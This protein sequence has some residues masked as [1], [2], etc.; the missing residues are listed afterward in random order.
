MWWR[1]PGLWSSPWGRL[2]EHGLRGGAGVSARQRYC[3][4][5]L[6]FV[7]GGFSLAGMTSSQGQC[8]HPVEADEGTDATCTE[9]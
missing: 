5:V 9:F 6:V 2:R 4:A 8:S 1:M 3:T 7:G